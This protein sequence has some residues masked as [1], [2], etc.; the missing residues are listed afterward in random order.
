MCIIITK[1][2]SGSVARAFVHW[3]TGPGFE[4]QVPQNFVQFFLQVFVCNSQR[5]V[6]HTPFS[7]CWPGGLKPNP[8]TRMGSSPWSQVSARIAN[9]KSQTQACS[10]WASKTADQTP[11]LGPN[12]LSLPLFFISFLLTCYLFTWFIFINY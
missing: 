3:L 5:R 8:M 7:R 1:E 11:S 9:H 4:S 12:P 6:H 10:K 2:A